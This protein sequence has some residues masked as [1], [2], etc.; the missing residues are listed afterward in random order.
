MRFPTFGPPLLKEHFAPGPPLRC[1]WVFHVKPDGTFRA[2]IVMMGQ[3][4][5]RG[6][7]YIWQ[8]FRPDAFGHCDQG[9]CHNNR[10]R[11][12]AVG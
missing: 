1:I 7:H 11:E 2:R 10:S 4:M 8:D 6:L 3:F 12:A 5:V 9:F